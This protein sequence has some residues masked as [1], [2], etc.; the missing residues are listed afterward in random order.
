MLVLEIYKVVNTV[1]DLPHTF[2]VFTPGSSGNFIAGILN[3]IANSNLESLEIS[4]SGSSHT[5]IHNKQTVGDSLSFGTHVEETALFSSDTDK[6]QHYLDRIKTEYSNIT[7]PLVTW[8]HNYSNILLYKK[9]FKNSKIL[10]IQSDTVNEKLTCV[11]MH[12]TKV[13]LDKNVKVPITSAAWQSLLERLEKGCKLELSQLLGTTEVDDIVKNRFDPNYKDIADYAVI[14]IMLK[15]FGMLGTVDTISYTEHNI[16]DY[17]VYPQKS[18]SVFYT[19]GKKVSEYVKEAD[20]VLPYSYLV[21]NNKDMLIEKLQLAVSRELSSAEKNFVEMSFNKY[22]AIQNHD[23]LTNPLEF[24]HQKKTKA[25]AF[26]LQTKIK[27]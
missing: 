19:I 13:L 24:Y 21:N 23:I 3:N 12:I 2:V 10:V 27:N 16:F 15:Y 7:S 4:A 11:F 8:T 5:V 22:R 1:F 17:M 9:Y 14:R 6:E 26:I 18:A 25:E 20:V